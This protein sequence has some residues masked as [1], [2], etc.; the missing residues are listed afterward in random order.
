MGILPIPL[1]G[2][3]TPYSLACWEHQ[4]FP[5]WVGEPTVP[6]LGG[7][8]T[9]LLDGTSVVRSHETSALALD[10]F[11]FFCETVSHVAQ[12]SLVAVVIERKWPP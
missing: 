8:T 11:C 2:G 10:L 6:L 12:A 9:Y 3:S 1:L 7:S 5:C 4:L